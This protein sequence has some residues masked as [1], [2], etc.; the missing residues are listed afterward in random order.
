MTDLDFDEL[1]K[2]VNS[3]M[4]GVK[5]KDTSDASKTLDISTT[6]AP[7]EKPTYGTLSQVA[8]RIGSE[9]IDKQEM[10]VSLGTN[11]ANSPQD[12]PVSTVATPS[13]QKPGRFMDVVHPSSD[14]KRSNSRV[15]SRPSREGATIETPVATPELAPLA[16]TVATSPVEADTTLEAIIPDTSS[17]LPVSSA[18][19]IELDKDTPESTPPPPEPIISPFLT[20]AKVEKRPLGGSEPTPP[21]SAPPID[22]VSPPETKDEPLLESPEVELESALGESEHSQQKDDSSV[23]DNLTDPAK[24]DEDTTIH[25]PEEYKDELLAV[26]KNTDTVTIDDKPL[27]HRGMSEPLTVA[28]IPKQYQEKPSSG[29]SKSGAIYDTDT[30]HKPLAHP[31]K[32]NSGWLWVIAIVVIIAL[33]AGAGAFVYFIGF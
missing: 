9:A 5:E 15:V 4:G 10:T 31:A 22:S 1:D 33:G 14:M 16:D 29:D 8:G 7:D 30:Y 13:S 6:L 28:S 26:E 12:T 21:I 20:N 27:T 24:E 3:L 25:V 17:D 23:M 2:A 18:P 19:E 11:A 32:K